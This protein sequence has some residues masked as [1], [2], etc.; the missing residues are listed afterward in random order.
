[1][2]CLQQVV[3]LGNAQPE[4]L[5]GRLSHPLREIADVT[6]GGALNDAHAVITSCSTEEELRELVLGAA[7]LLGEDR[8]GLVY[9]DVS[10]VSEALSLEI[11]HAANA[12]GALYLRAPLTQGPA[13]TPQETAVTAMVSGSQDAFDAAR[14]ILEGLAEKIVYLGEGEEARAMTGVLDVMTGVTLGMWAEALVFGEAAGLDWR[15]MVQVMET[16]AIASPL[17]KDHAARVSH[18]DYES[19]LTCAM[20]GERLSSALER[21]KSTG[22][23]LTLTGLA[24]QMFV[25]ALGS[26]AAAS[27]STSV[28]PWLEAAAGMQPAN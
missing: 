7:G 4:F 11:A 5:R 20:L 17:I 24:H 22:V 23:V 28:I 19:A 16:S 18:F 9:I 12:V 15:D 1:M 2:K 27:G 13:P 25:G 6:L 21:G 10:W 3:L 26:G 14:L 8:K